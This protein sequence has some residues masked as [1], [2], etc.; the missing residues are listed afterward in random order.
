MSRLYLYNK[1]GGLLLT[2]GSKSYSGH[3]SDEYTLTADEHLTGFRATGDSY[4]NGLELW[5]DTE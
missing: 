1:S 4:L 3:Y 5:V 2:C